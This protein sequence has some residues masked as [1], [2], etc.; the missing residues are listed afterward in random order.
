MTFNTIKNRVK[1]LEIESVI[2]EYTV[3]LSQAMLDVE[4]LDIEIYTDGSEKIEDLINQ[5]GTHRL[6]GTAYRE[7][8]RKYVAGALVAGT[9]EFFELKGFLESLDS[10]T[11]VKLHPVKTVYSEAPPH[12]KLRSRGRKVRFT[13]NQLQVLKCLSENV[14]MPISQIAKRIN[15]TPRRVGR[16]LRELEEGGGVHFTI[17]INWFTLGDVILQY[18]IRYDETKT[19]V[20]EIVNWFKEHYPL[21]FWG[22]GQRLDEP[23]ITVDIIVEN[24]KKMGDITKMVREATF[25]EHVDD[26]VLTPQTFVRVRYRDPSQTRLEEMFQEAGL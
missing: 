5:I 10:V 25:V 13:K 1:K 22:A 14:R 2:Q 9:A 17:R 16:I 23:V 21:E 7:Q 24:Q 26:V 8:N 20:G 11:R 19:S 4:G 3:E 18:Y 15:L 12:S 6:I